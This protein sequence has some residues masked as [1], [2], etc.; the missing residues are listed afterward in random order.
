MRA[1]LFALVVFVTSIASAPPPGRVQLEM[2]NVHYRPTD[3][4]ALDIV[5]LRGEMQTLGGADHPIL[6]D[7]T[8]FRVLIRKAVVRIPP[9]ALAASMNDVVFSRPGAPVKRVRVET[10]DGRMTLSGS[11]T[12]DG[13]GVPFETVSEVSPEPDGRLR[14]HPLSMKSLGVG[15]KGLE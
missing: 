1:A 6:G 10:R 15:V 7:A 9:D 4:V 14:I 12:K 11:L 13:V 8:T 3:D 5:S 2:K